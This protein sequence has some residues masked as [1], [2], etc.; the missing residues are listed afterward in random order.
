MLRTQRRSLSTQIG[1]S[2][3]AYPLLTVVYMVSGK[4]G[5]MLAVPPGYASPIDRKSVV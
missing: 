1:K 3:F 2:V 5:L 4:L